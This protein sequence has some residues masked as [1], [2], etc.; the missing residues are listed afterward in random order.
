MLWSAMAQVNTAARG[1]SDLSSVR[2]QVDTMVAQS[3]SR[4]VNGPV[5]ETD[6]SRP[7]RGPDAI[8][9]GRD[10]NHTVRYYNLTGR[11]KL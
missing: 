11:D 2:A 9:A 10:Y 3:V 5:P 7:A 6:P 4:P 8:P 1:M